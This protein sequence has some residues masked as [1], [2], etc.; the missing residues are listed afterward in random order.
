[1]LF[2][3]FASLHL[4]LSNSILTDIVFNVFSFLR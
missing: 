3:L 2:L 1:M 4:T